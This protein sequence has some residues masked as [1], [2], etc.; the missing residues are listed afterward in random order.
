MLKNTII[1]TPYQSNIKYYLSGKDICFSKVLSDN[2]TFPYN[3]GIFKHTISNSNNPL[4]NIIVF[5]HSLHPGTVIAIRIIGGFTYTDEKGIHQRIISV[6][7]SN[8]TD[9]IIELKSFIL[10]EIKLF[11]KTYNNI[12]CDRKISFGNFIN[13]DE[14]LDI[15]ND[16]RVR[17][18]KTQLNNLIY[19]DNL[20]NSINNTSESDNSPSIK[21]NDII[22]TNDSIKSDKSDISVKKRFSNLFRKS[23]K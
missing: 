21:T 11:F 6:P 15:Y 12:C 16:S 8:N 3:T 20:N 23:K 17:W 5:K 22:K 4:K 7:C 14:S 18:E 10:D 1:V 13:R 19:N 2:L 9:N